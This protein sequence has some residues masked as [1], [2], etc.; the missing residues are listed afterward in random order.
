MVHDY[1]IITT[2]KEWEDVHS[3]YLDI[4]PLFRSFYQITR[5]SYRISSSDSIIIHIQKIWNNLSIQN[6]DA[7]LFYSIS[8][9]AKSWRLQ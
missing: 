8:V 6:N 2:N 1:K 3:M 7:L 5:N 4:K 9:L